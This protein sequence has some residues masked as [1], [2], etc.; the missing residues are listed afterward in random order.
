MI[1]DEYEDDAHFCLRCHAT[2][3]GIDNYVGHRKAGCVKGGG[4][5]PDPP[6]S[7][8]PSQLLPPDESFD[9]KADD[10][11]SSLEL[12]S[13]SKRADSQAGAGG[14]HLTGILT[15]SRTTAVIQAAASAPK[16][17]TEAQQSKSGKNVWIGGDQL[18]ELG[19]GDNHSKLIKAV[20]NLERRKEEPPKLDVFEDSEDESDEFDFED[21]E[22]SS[23]D[24]DV[25]PRHHTGGKWKPSSPVQ[26]ARSTDS[27]TWNVPP[28]TFT[29]GKWKP[30]Y[31][32]SSTPPPT[33]TKGKWPPPSFTGSKWVPRK[34]E[35][36]SVP[37]PSFTGSKWVA[38]KKQDSEDIYNKGRGKTKLEIDEEKGTTESDV[39][40]AH[41]TKGKW[42]PRTEEDEDFPPPSYTKGK[43]KP[44]PATEPDPPQPSFSKQKTQSSKSIKNDTNKLILTVPEETYT[45]GK[46]LPPTDNKS[47]SKLNSQSLLRKSGGTIQYWCSPCN[48]RLASKVVY[49]RHL[50]SELHFKRTAHDRDFDETG[51]LL[52]RSVRR[53]KLKLSEPIFSSD[54]K[55]TTSKKRKRRKVYERCD[56]CLSRVNKYLIGKHLISHYHCRK[57]NIRTEEARRMVLDNIHDIVLESPFQCSACKFYCNTH[58]DFLRH[59]LSPEHTCKVLP[60]HFFCILCKFRTEDTGLMYAHLVSDEH[61]EVVSVINRSLPIVIKKINPVACPTCHQEFMLNVQLLEHCKKFNHDDSSAVKFKNQFICD[62]CGV[63]LESNNAVK[64]H[65]RV[66][67]NANFFV[68]NPCG[69]RFES[70]V[71]AKRHRKSVQHKYLA[72]GEK[73][74]KEKTCEY[75]QK[76]FGNFLLLKE[77][78][79]NFHPEQKIRCPHC[80]TSFAIAQDLSAHLRNKSCKFEENSLDS[81]RCGKCPFT[82]ASASELFFH[83]A[84]HEPPSEAYP[85]GVEGKKTIFR[86]KCPVCEKSFPKGSLEAHIRQHTQ[87][88]PYV[89]RIC[90]KSF[91]RKNNLQFHLKNHEKKRGKL[92]VPTAGERPY[93]CSVCGASFK[94]KS[95]LQQHMQIHTGKE[96]KCPHI[97]CVYTARKMSEI[98]Q[99]FKIHQDAKEH[100]CQ[101]C[102]YKGKT[103]QHLTRHMT[104]H[105]NTKRYQCSQC[106]F[107]SR[108]S[109]HLRR[110]IR[111]HTGAKPFSC[112]YCNYKCN[113]LENLRKHILSTNKHPGKCIYECKFCA[114]DDADTT[115]FQ[116]NF[117]KDFKAHLV[118]RH[119]ETFGN[120][121]EAA[122]YVAGIYDVQDDS[123]FLGHVGRT[124]LEGIDDQSD[125]TDPNLRDASD[126]IAC[127]ISPPLSHVA[128]QASHLDQML[129]EFPISKD[130]AI[131]KD[132]AI[133]K[134]DR[135][136]A[137]VNVDNLQDSW[138]LVGR[139]D[140]EE[141]SGTLIPFQSEDSDSLFQG[142]F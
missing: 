92:I 106:S 42:K 126:A 46:W 95:I 110:H 40:L 101:V 35:D 56:V 84:L 124:T 32:R 12:R 8:P 81:L 59:W 50:K 73:S 140:V 100:A 115:P 136:G 21:E 94:R 48:R 41:H 71:E 125:D 83:V 123:T 9:L 34:Q 51:E 16:D 117:A 78:I 49:E 86:Y 72:S 10:F 111:I 90:D 105:A 76:S 30:S 77:H 55:A 23:D 68:C 45:K 47:S 65:H 11:F 1:A 29:G 104:L 28:P 22:S 3:L 13:S 67:H 87:E 60:G 33:H 79:G 18:K 130:F 133:P 135:G 134:D 132:Y 63:G 137:T 17:P 25:P 80:G 15:R 36:L 52:M 102:E 93:L 61:T 64:R 128:P 138:S 98:N 85:D 44:K 113:N 69:L 2:V 107:T 37:P 74:S 57:G 88:R 121:A 19:H 5:V 66:A 99:H 39:P 20:A 31:K 14:K 62:V 127:R 122:T 58:R 116:T 119:Q 27:S 97:G 70:A 89:C 103:K 108:D 141:E 129:P 7:P 4:A 24:Q 139:Y 109:T 96:C 26:W 112:P 114:G 75:C 120:G 142:H 43:W 38:P 53:P 54:E 6:K 118:M 91:A 131:S 82:S